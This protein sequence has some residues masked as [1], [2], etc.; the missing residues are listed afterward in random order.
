MPQRLAAV[1]FVGR[2]YHWAR[3][4]FLGEEFSFAEYPIDDAE[5][6]NAARDYRSH[7]DGAAAVHTL[8][9]SK[10]PSW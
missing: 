6:D 7:L 1:R 9:G 3:H 4:H 10:W 2:Y 8:T 5:G